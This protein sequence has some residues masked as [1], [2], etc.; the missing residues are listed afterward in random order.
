M[1][2]EGKLILLIW[3]FTTVT[4]VASILFGWVDDPRDIIFLLLVLAVFLIAI[5]VDS[6]WSRHNSTTEV[7]GSKAAS[8]EE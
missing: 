4:V 6:K 7:S 3:I 8:R 5:L 2:H 1:D